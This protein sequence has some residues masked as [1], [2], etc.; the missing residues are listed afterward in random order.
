VNQG[1]RL[2]RLARLLLN[3]PLGRQP[4]KLIVD[5]RQQLFRGVGVTIFDSGQDASDFRHGD[6]NVERAL[7]F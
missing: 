1:R 6:P 5:E 2:E 7:I 3:Q 4:A